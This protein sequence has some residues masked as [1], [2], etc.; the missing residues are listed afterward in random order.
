MNDSYNCNDNSQVIDN[1][2]N[3][4][5]LS[6]WMT[7]LNFNFQYLFSVFVAYAIQS[8]DG[9]AIVYVTIFTYRSEF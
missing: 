2:D 6:I 9:I 5:N 7:N 4:G 3:E 1:N 8:I